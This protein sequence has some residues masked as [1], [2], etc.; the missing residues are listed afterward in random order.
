MAYPKRPDLTPEEITALYTLPDE[1]LLTI[2]EASAFIRL[3]KQTLAFY[4]CKGGGPAFI[5]VG[6]TIRYRMAD[7]R[8]NVKNEV[9]RHG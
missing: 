8:G 5:K 3:T 1:A 7:L 2:A 9:A 6:K 4:R